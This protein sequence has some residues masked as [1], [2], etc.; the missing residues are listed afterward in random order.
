MTLPTDLITHVFTFLPVKKA[1]E[2]N[3]PQSHIDH[4]VRL[5]KHYRRIQSIHPEFEIGVF[6]DYA[7]VTYESSIC[8][9]YE[10]SRYH[11]KPQVFRRK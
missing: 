5:N 7:L 2:M 10:W 11:N 6:Q 4:I 8:L 3:L 1:I 9:L